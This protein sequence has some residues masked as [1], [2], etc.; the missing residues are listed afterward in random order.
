MVEGRVLH[1][2]VAQDVTRRPGYVRIVLTVAA[3]HPAA[4]APEG[5]TAEIAY[6]HAVPVAGGTVVDLFIVWAGA[7]M[8]YAGPVLLPCDQVLVV[9]HIRR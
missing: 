6:S 9:A 7:G 8:D 5:T 1:G 3:S 2:G 4:T